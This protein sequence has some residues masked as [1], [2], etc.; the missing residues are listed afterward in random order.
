V[1]CGLVGGGALFGVVWLLNFCWFGF[2][3]AEEEPPA[4]AAVWS[5][6]ERCWV[7]PVPWSKCAY[8]YDA[9]GVHEVP[10]ASAYLFSVNKFRVISH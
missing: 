4:D 10:Y 3:G 1:Q 9:M 2:A 8:H 5:G 7:R 6:D